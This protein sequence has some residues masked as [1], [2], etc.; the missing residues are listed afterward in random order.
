MQIEITDKEID[1]AEQILLPKDCHFDIERRNFIK[2]LSTLDLQAV[3]GSGK[4]TALLA[5]LLILVLA[6]NWAVTIQI[7]VY[8]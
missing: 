5:K 6:K 4:T 2:D 1:Y 3:P 7:I 8:H